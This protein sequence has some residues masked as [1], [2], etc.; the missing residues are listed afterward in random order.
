MCLSNVAI[1]SQSGAKLWQ[2]TAVV[3]ASSARDLIAESATGPGNQRLLH[4]GLSLSTQGGDPLAPLHSLL[5]TGQKA[6]AAL[7][8]SGREKLHLSSC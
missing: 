7:S 3:C 8:V 2:E 1:L 5:P 4:P 6:G